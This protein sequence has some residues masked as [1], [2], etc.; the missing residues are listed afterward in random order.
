MA[1]ILPTWPSGTSLADRAME[2]ERW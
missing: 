1:K 2:G